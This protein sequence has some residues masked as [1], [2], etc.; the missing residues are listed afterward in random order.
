MSV[1][2]SGNPRTPPE[3]LSP[4]TCATKMYSPTN[5]DQPKQR[6]CVSLSSMCAGFNYSLLND[7]GVEKGTQAD[8]W[9]VLL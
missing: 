6:Y 4:V 7:T 1:G 3:G 8:V 9:R 5:T 2:T